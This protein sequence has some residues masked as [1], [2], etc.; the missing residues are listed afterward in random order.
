MD[1]RLNRFLKIISPA[2]VFFVCLN[3]TV[4]SKA[5]ETKKYQYHTLGGN[6]NYYNVA[7]RYG[8][9]VKMLMDEN[10]NKELHLGDVLRWPIAATRPIQ[11]VDKKSIGRLPS[12]MP[13]QAKRAD[14]PTALSTKKIDAPLLSEGFDAIHKLWDRIY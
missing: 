6:D 13:K 10:D 8:I 12:V 14:V 11:R 3:V 4:P 2:I 7:R 1:I 9:D 5:Q